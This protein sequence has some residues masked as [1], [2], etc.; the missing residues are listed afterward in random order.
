M[1]E[2]IG[3]RREGEE[4]A[5]LWRAEFGEQG[6]C[7]GADLCNERAVSLADME[8]CLPRKRHGQ[9]KF[10]KP[11]PSRL[12]HAS[13]I[14]SSSLSY[15]GRRH[16]KYSP[17]SPLPVGE[18]TDHNTTPT[19]PS[20]REKQKTTQKQLLTHEPRIVPPLKCIFLD[21]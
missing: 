18:G 20:G 6:V 1:I 13:S 8:G 12:L 4:E 21:P 16:F 5:R 11:L 15:R 10:G 19:G 2:R 17:T 9:Y 14:S 3:K 7:A